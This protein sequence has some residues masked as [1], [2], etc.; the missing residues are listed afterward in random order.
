MLPSSPASCAAENRP[1]PITCNSCSPARSA[2]RRAMNSRYHSVER[3]TAPRI[4][5][6]T[7]GPGG[8]APVSIRSSSLRSFGK[9]P[10]RTR[11]KP[12]AK[13]PNIRPQARKPPKTTRPCMLM[14]PIAKH[15]DGFTLAIPCPILRR[16]SRCSHSYGGLHSLLS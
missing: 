13:V 7:N 16:Q 14:V 4:G 10:A 6:G 2:A 1:I 12:C 11:V 9:K 5:P 15:R 8:R 3:T